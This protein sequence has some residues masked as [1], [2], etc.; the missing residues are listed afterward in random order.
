MA[1][2]AAAPKPRWSVAPF[3]VVG[4]VVAT[5]NFDRDKLGFHY[6]RFGAIRPGSPWFAA[7]ESPSCSSSWR[8]ADRPNSTVDPGGDLWDA[9]I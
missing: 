3:F 9:Y 1:D 4:D 5:A 7:P 2:D 8:Q 6:D